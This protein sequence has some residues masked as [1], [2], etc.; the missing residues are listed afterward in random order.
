VKVFPANNSN[1]HKLE[2]EFPGRLGLLLGPSGLRNPKD[3]PFACDNDIFSAWS[4][5]GFSSNISE[6]RST[7]DESAFLAMFDWLRDRHRLPL[8]IVA[9]DVPGNALQT[10][11]QFRIWRPRIEK[12]GFRAAMAVQDGM[13][14]SDVPSGVVAF[15]GGTTAWKW[16]NVER[17][18]GECD[19][20]HVGRV[21]QY[22]RL[23]QCHEA[24]AESC[25]GTGFFRGDQNQRRGLIQYLTE[26]T[27]S[28]RKPERQLTLWGN[29]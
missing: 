8:W 4:R 14:P 12:A 9:P 24:G 7:W 17:F 20:C 2:A 21:N 27:T 16:A 15:I 6:Q 19:R 10:I 25:D 23:W 1:A 13:T 28:T 11:Q 18:C 3:L 29:K 5:S 26:S 22:R